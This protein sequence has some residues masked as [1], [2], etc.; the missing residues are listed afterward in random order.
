[1]KKRF[2]V[3]LISGIIVL[4][5]S[6]K[7]KPTRTT[8]K[9]EKIPEITAPVDTLN[10]Y[11]KLIISINGGNTKLD[12]L[13]HIKEYST[14]PFP[15]KTII[16]LMGFSIKELKS[17]TVIYSDSIKYY[18]AIESE[19]G[20]YISIQDRQGNQ[21]GS[22]EIFSKKNNAGYANYNYF[23]I[24]PNDI[25]IN[26]WNNKNNNEMTGDYP[27]IENEDYLHIRIDDKGRFS[28]ID[29]PKN[30]VDYFCILPNGYLCNYVEVMQC[31]FTDLKDGN[32]WYCINKS[33]AY[34]PIV[35]N[36]NG[37]VDLKSRMAQFNANGIPYFVLTNSAGGTCE[38]FLYHHFFTYDAKTN[39]FTNIPDNDILPEIDKFEL[40]KQPDLIR[41]KFK[42]DK[43]Q[44]NFIPPRYGTTMKLEPYI[45]ECGV[46]DA[47]VL[48]LIH[49]IKPIGLKWNKT[50][51]KFEKV[52]LN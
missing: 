29:K 25:R 7:N 37:Y 45:D 16:S 24:T 27:I 22:G 30:I 39:L 50:I 31:S 4:C 14:N 20:L 42:E 18:V 15:E 33:K 36:K 23:L 28:K 41:E 17:T 12:V 5:Y 6:F 1:M 51:A 19:N 52:T 34:Q 40:F 2:T 9:E 46:E 47:V 26:V 48:N 35:D 38:S 21:L 49:Q 32:D 10:K 8:E 11:N 13:D 43:I 3:I 44:L